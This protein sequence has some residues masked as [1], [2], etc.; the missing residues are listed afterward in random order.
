MNKTKVMHQPAP[1]K[2]YVEPNIHAN[3]QRLSAVDKSTYLGSTLSSS[4][5][6]NDEVNSRIAKASVAFGRLRSNV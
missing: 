4:I 6:I 2:T 5:V 3:S 1:G